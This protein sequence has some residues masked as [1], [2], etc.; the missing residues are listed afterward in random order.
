MTNRASEWAGGLAGTAYPPLAIIGLLLASSALPADFSADPPQIAAHL[1]SHPPSTMTWLGVA[2]EL[3]A[4]AG[5]LVFVVRCAWLMRHWMAAAAAALGAAAVTIKVASFVP[6]LVA[7]TA[8]EG[9]EASELALLM[10]LNDLAVPVSESSLAVFLILIS[11]AAGAVLP[12]WLAWGA[13]L[14]GLGSLLDIAG[15]PALLSL[16]PL[17]WFL[18]AGAVVARYRDPAPDREPVAAA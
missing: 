3:L 18:L 6:V 7:V 14:A 9:L 11:A 16:L 12:R 10:R 1:A 17:I 8:A 2:L 5:L 4:L 13:C 15:G